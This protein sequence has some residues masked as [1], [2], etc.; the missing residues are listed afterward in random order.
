MNIRNVHLG[1]ASIV[2]LGALAGCA[3]QPP[4]DLVSARSAVQQAQ[5][6]PDLARYAPAELAEAQ[7]K[8]RDADDAFHEGDD[9]AE[10]THK[11]NLVQR[12]VEVARTEADARKN[13]QVAGQQAQALQQQLADLQ[14]RQTDRGMVFTV[15]DVLFD[16]GQA[17][18]K[19]GAVLE[20]NRLAQFL[21]QTPNSQ[22]T[23]EGHTDSTGSANFNEMLSQQRAEAVRGALVSAGA[24]PSRVTAV[25]MGPSL[26]V[27]SNDT[28][29]GRQ[30]N[31][32]VEIIVQNPPTAAAP[33]VSSAAGAIGQAR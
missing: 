11:A 33:Q 19:P 17:T 30:Q 28:A 31:R 1:A 29:A 4:S 15:G 3:G 21:Q 16:T 24:D 10:V 23:I 14:P 12:Q 6:S 26:P 20:I 18:L 7:V 2:V 22:V 5:T 9:Q 27:A 8:L 25:G 13:Q 32:R